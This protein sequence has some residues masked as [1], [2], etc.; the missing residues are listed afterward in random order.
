MLGPDHP[1][2]VWKKYQCVYASVSRM[3]VRDKRRVFALMREEH[4]DCDTFLTEHG[5]TMGE[6]SMMHLLADHA[7]K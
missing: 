4:V 7:R 5:V 6:F 1:Y 2:P 3:T